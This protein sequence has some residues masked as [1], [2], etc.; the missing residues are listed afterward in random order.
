MIIEKENN[1]SNNKE[2]YTLSF[3]RGIASLYVVIGH[4]MIWGGYKGYF[5][6][7][8]VAVDVFIF[9]SGF[10]IFGG[11]FSKKR[12]L[13]SYFKHRF[14]RIAPCYYFSILVFTLLY[15]YI[16]EGLVYIQSLDRTRWPIGSK[17]DAGLVVYDLKSIL[18]HISFIFGLFPKYSQSSYVGDWSISLEMQFYLLA[19]V[20]VVFLSR[21]WSV[22]ILTLIAIYACVF[23]SLNA[24]TLSFTEPSLIIIKLHIFILGGVIFL[25]VRMRGLWYRIFLISL[26]LLLIYAQYWIQRY[27][28][29]SNNSSVYLLISIVLV[30]FYKNLN[31]IF[32]NF[33]VRFLSN[34]SY[35]LYLI[36]GVF[37]AL[38]G[39]IYMKSDCNVSLFVL[40]A[41][42]TIPLS[43][44]SAWLISITIEKKGMEL[45]KKEMFKFKSR[46]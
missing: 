35:P 37:I 29:L 34:I 46:Q 4:V 2:I 38:S 43:I 14:F 18:M 20:L 10:L 45:A 42:V 41:I 33:I 6:N 28:F 30:L 39:L 9:I 26:A 32:N 8:K 13:Q 25:A 24:Y 12:G 40:M 16:N 23:S 7:P 21:W 44:L 36:H 27:T 22:C 19:P 17:Y 11:F 15:P 3:L 5:P 1:Q 31:Y